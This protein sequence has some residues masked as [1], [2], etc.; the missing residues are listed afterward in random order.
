VVNIAKYYHHKTVYVGGK[1]DNIYNNIYK[2]LDIIK[3]TNYKLKDLIIPLRPARVKI[4]VKKGRS[5]NRK[6][7]FSYTN[8]LL[9][10]SKRICLSSLFKSK[11][12]L[13]ILNQ[14]Y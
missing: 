7:L 3:A 13:V 12:Y 11:R 9:L 6:R 14:V 1:E 10:P 2:G 5:F 8:A 4:S